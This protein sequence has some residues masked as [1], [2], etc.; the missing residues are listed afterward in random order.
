M[1]EVV[2]EVVVVEAEAGVEDVED[3]EVEVVVVVDVVVVADVVVV[4]DVVVVA[5]VVLMT[6]EVWRI[7]GD[8]MMVMLPC[9]LSLQRQVRHPAMTRHRGFVRRPRHRPRLEGLMV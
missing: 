1:A 7:D 3:V 4:E 8:R 6:L 2:A 9:R 5:A